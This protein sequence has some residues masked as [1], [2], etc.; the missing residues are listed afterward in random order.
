VSVNDK[1]ILIYSTFPDLAV[2]ERVGGEIVAAGM[3]ACANIIPGMVSLYIWK[4]TRH[5]DSEVVMLLKSRAGLQEQVLAEVKRQHPYEN[6]ALLV[7]EPTGG[8]A[9]FIAWIL[10]Q[11]TVASS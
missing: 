3:A 8:S 4:G 1:P 11:T 10:A 9:E 7:L 2:A 5:R 6:P